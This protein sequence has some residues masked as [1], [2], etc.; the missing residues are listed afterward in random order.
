M[1]EAPCGQEAVLR[2]ERGARRV[3]PDLPRDGMGR[4][5]ESV[6]RPERL[7]SGPQGN[8]AGQGGLHLKVKG[9]GFVITRRL[10]K[11]P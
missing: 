8:S 5:G 7:L 1:S 2:L 4:E 3:G 9:G 10:E 11:P 6:G